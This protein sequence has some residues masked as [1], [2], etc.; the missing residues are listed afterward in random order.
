M[1]DLV[2]EAILYATI[3]HQGKVRK[4]KNI[5]FILHPLEVAQIL[6]TMTDDREVIAAGILHDVVEDTDGTLDEIRSR[7]GE[8]VAHLVDSE[9]E[10]AYPEESKAKSWRKR[11]EQSLQK[12]RQ[13]E[14]IGVKMLWLAD[15][16]ANIRSLA[17]DCSENGESVW[18]HFHQKD[19]SM[20]CWYY[21]T[22]A[23]YVEY[24]L[25]KTGAYKE[26]IKQINYIWPGTFD[27][28]KTRY[29]KY[30][31]VSLE[32]CR[33][34]GS[35]QKGDVYRY[36]DEL[37]LKVYNRR[38]TYKDVEREI[39]LSR[40]AFVLG[41]PTAISFGIVSVQDRYGAMYELIGS[42]T[43]TSCIAAHPFNLEYYADAMSDLAQIIHSTSAEEEDHFPDARDRFRAY[44]QNGIAFSSKALAHRCLQLID[45][46]PETK[47]L[48]HGDFHTSNVF[49]QNSEPLLIDMDR[50][51]TGDPIFELG[52][53]YLY[54]ASEQKKDPNDPD[55]YFGLPYGICRRFYDL[56]LKHYLQT[57]DAERLREVGD[58]AA[59]LGNL[60]LINRYRKKDVLSEEEKS[61]VDALAADVKALLHRVERLAI[62]QSGSD[63]LS[64]KERQK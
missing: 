3:M 51:A 25:N 23:E 58:R 18:K 61:E 59:L 55:P 50:L 26:M 53:L 21:R 33:L 13:S 4:R 24:D 39:A 52:D 27:S 8:R 16:L 31:E 43:M 20:H 46:M 34:L 64:G 56:F 62:A 44:I 37:V 42:G 2:E 54:Y 30:K 7:F 1:M 60:R 17:R 12:L 15:K 32:G 45:E 38:N 57:E 40:R 28:E 10:A 49:L 5:P 29:R 47:H 14:D 11:K 41:I 19:P 35:G 6:A 36:D 63:G 9:T 48:I 22:V